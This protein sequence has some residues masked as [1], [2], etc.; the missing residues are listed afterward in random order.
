MRRPGTAVLFLLVAGCSLGPIESFDSHNFTQPPEIWERD[1]GYFL[2]VYETFPD[3]AGMAPPAVETLNGDVYVFIW[4][5]HSNG[6]NPKRLFDLGVK[7]TNPPPRFFW[8]NPD[9]SRVAMEL[10]RP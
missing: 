6:G 2:R 4:G 3:P 7:A 9:Q 1:G 8:I 10:V 5:R